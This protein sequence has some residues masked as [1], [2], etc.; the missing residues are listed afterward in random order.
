MGIC[1]CGF[2]GSD[3]TA[4]PRCQPESARRCP[5]YG[6]RLSFTEQR[7]LI[8]A[9][10]DSASGGSFSSCGE[11]YVPCRNM[12]RYGLLAPGHQPHTW[13]LTPLARDLL[14]ACWY[15]S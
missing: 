13:D 7:T 5:S 8:E 11:T 15:V 2:V 6:I 1:S 9:F 12:E 10:R 3:W 4:C 14:E